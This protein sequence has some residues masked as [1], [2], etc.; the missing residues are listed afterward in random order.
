MTA[1][2]KH[3]QVNAGRFRDTHHCPFP[4]PEKRRAALQ[5]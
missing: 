3:R 1:C 4:E 2:R 5:P